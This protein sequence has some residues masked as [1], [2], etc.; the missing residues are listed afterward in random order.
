MRKTSGDEEANEV[1]ESIRL[2]LEEEDPEEK[3]SFRDL[4]QPALRLVLMIG[5]IVAV[6]QQITG[7]NSVFFYAPIIFE[8]SGIGTDASFSQAIYVG[9]I[10]LFFT[11]LA[12]SLIDKLGP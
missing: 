5:V 11:I 4:F 3:Q 6:L 7:I 9:L 10:N 8:Q 12:I 1:I 2:R